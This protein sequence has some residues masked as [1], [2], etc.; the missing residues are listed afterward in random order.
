MQEGNDWEA[1]YVEGDFPEAYAVEATWG[2][3]VVR[4]TLGAML[5]GKSTI[6]GAALWLLGED[7]YGQ[8][9]VLV[10]CDDHPSDL[11]DFHY[12][13][14]GDRHSN[15]SVSRKHVERSGN[16]VAFTPDTQLERRRPLSLRFPL[17]NQLL[18]RFTVGVVEKLDP[19]LRRV[20][21]LPNHGLP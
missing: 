18:H 14:I 11:G 6:H 12:R 21:C 8:A 7:V 17:L 1:Q 4:E 2:V 16:H 5:A 3:E 10:R 15:D 13:V 9:D 20:P 19:L